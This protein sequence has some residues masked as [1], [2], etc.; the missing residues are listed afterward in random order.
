MELSE[1][2]TGMLE[3]FGNA[4]AFLTVLDEKGIARYVACAMI[5]RLCFT[6]C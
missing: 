2:D 3:E 4:A 1:D 5:H 6:V